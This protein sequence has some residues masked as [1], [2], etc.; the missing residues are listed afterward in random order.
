MTTSYAILIGM[1]RGLSMVEILAAAA[2][3]AA[4]LIPVLQLFMDSTRQWDQQRDRMLAHQTARLVLQRMASNLDQ[5]FGVAQHEAKPVIG[6][7]GTA[8]PWLNLF[9]ASSTGIT[10]DWPLMQQW[11]RDWKLKTEMNSRP[12]TPDMVELSVTVL[13]PSGSSERELKLSMWHRKGD[14]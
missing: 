13:Y 11:M 2:I 1:R 10:T 5:G 12:D 4:F 7:G 9:A 8:T 6:E 14:L 3:L